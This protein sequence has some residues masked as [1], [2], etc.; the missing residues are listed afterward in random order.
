[1]YR[2]GFTLIELLVVL[3]VVLILAGLLLP[4]LGGAYAKARALEDVNAV[5]QA[6]LVAAIYSSDFDDFYPH[7]GRTHHAVDA[8]FGWYQLL[9]RSGH[10]TSISEVDPP[11]YRRYAPAA[12]VSI[13]M[14]K[15]VVLPPEQMRPGW[16]P[17]FDQLLQIPIRTSRL[18]YPAQKGVFYKFWFG[19]PEDEIVFC[20]GRDLRP[21]VN[22]AS[23]VAMGDGSVRVGTCVDFNFGRNDYSTTEHVGI[24]VMST[25]GGVNARDVP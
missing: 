24:P 22:P 2:R 23:P 15:C 16:V 7:H 11:H 1:M 21:G 19:L 20:L 12:S 25:W 5:R 10:Y 6:A 9:L 17:P 8:S 4:A 3:G 14:S 18:T 13:H